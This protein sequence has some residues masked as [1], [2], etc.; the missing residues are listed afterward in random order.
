[1]LCGV[2][3]LRDD[4]RVGVALRCLKQW[5]EQTQRCFSSNV[6]RASVG[7]VGHLKSLLDDVFLDESLGKRT[8]LNSVVCFAIE[9]GVKLSHVHTIQCTVRF[10]DS[11]AREKSGEFTPKVDIKFSVQVLGS[12]GHSLVHIG[13]GPAVERIRFVVHRPGARNLENRADSVSENVSQPRRGYTHG[14]G[15]LN[16]AR[17]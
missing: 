1:M 14:F 2:Q 6:V 15:R 4:G 12:F 13:N 7:N 17:E 16:A 9:L 8:Y 3:I 10:D 5:A 11:D